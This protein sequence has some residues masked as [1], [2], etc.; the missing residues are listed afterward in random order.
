MRAY[1]AMAK[2]H[3]PVLFHS[4]VLWDGHVSSAF[5]RPM[6][7]E[8]LME[9]T[10]LRFA[11]AHV[12]W[13]WYDECIAL[14]GKI[15]SAEHGGSNHVYS[16][17]SMFI[18]TTPGTPFIYR[19]QVFEKLFLIDYNLKERTIFGSD[20]SVNNFDPR[21]VQLWLDWDYQIVEK[22]RSTADNRIP[23]PHGLPSAEE[24]FRK[25]TQDNYLKFLKG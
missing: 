22:I 23:L 10:N 5:N 15:L 19:E 16:K 6:A 13:P 8:G 21:M 12:S 3:L 17:V 2:H 18:D 9:V 25:I 24:I 20:C 7:F 4:G 11:L 1:H 14:F